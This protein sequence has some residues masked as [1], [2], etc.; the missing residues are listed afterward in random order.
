MVRAESHKRIDEFKREVNQ[1]NQTVQ[2][3]GSDLTGY[4]ESLSQITHKIVS[5][6]SCSDHCKDTRLDEYSAKLSEIQKQATA[7]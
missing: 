6:F 3:L 7:K 4:Q 2:M 5:F 1:V